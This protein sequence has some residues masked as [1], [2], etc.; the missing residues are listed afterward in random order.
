MTKPGRRRWIALA[1]VASAGLL[2]GCYYYPFGYYPWGYAYPYPYPA[3]YPYGA[4]Y[5][6]PP[7]AEAVPPTARQPEVGA[8]QPLNEPVQRSPLPPPAAQ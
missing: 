5:P 6:S 7:A 2:S 4:A 1:A 3:G 8:P